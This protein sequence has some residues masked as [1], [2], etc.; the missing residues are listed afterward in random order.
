MQ[1][2]AT[3]SPDFKSKYKSNDF[4]YEVK[5]SDKSLWDKF[6]DWLAYWFKKIFGLSDTK[7]SSDYVEITLKVLAGLIVIYVVYLIVKVIL[8]KEGQWVFG[9]STTKKILHDDDIAWKP[10]SGRLFGNLL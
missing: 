9:K 3:I 10:E 5:L 8:N 7:V 6:K 1:K 2:N 4:K